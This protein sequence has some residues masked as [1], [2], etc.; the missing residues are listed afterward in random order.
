MKYLK[1]IILVLAVSATC[2][3]QT[4]TISLTKQG[5][6]DFA[7][8]NNL[9]LRAVKIGIDEA[10]GRLHQSGR[11]ENPSLSLEYGTTKIIRDGDEFEFSVGISQKFPLTNRLSKETDVSQIDV[12]LAEMEY[13]QAMRSLAL[14][15]EL[16][17]INAQEKLA[18]LKTKKDA[19]K[20][21]DDI[22]E[23]IR[24]ASER[25]EASPI[26]VNLARSESARYKNEIIQDEIDAES[27]IIELETLLGFSHSQKLSI[28]ETLAPAENPNVKFSSTLLENRPDYQ[29]FKLAEESTKAQIALI[30]AKKFEDPEIGIFY[31]RSRR[32]D[33]PRGLINEDALGIALSIPLPFNSFDGSIQEKLA[34]RRRAE[35]LSTSKEIDIRNEIRIWQMRFNKYSEALKQFDDETIALVKKSETDLLKA[36]KLGQTEIIEVLN[37]RK[38]LFELQI[39]R[40]N[41]IAQLSASASNLK[42]SEFKNTKEEK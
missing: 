27:A 13:A 37:I 2:F 23:T 41:I 22:I 14:K 20:V 15:V 33:E 3:A 21:F 24:Q 34:S 1:F 4:K 7:L 10:K 11:L 12:R 8:K 31:S 28:A 39:R 38:N 30:K 42:A 35:T 29:M 17:Y 19:L 36:Q 6:V 18:V 25:G 16:A 9:E 32:E 5:A 26:S 40:T